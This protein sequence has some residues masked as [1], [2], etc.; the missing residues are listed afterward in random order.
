MF[1]M[2]KKGP[3]FVRCQL[4]TEMTESACPGEMMVLAM[5]IMMFKLSSPPKVLPFLTDDDDDN[6]D[7][8]PG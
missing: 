3:Y 1:N 7:N 4:G 6:G 5:T 2:N 8:G